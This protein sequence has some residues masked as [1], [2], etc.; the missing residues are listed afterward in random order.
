MTTTTRQVLVGVT[1]PGENTSALRWAA[2]E[3]AARHAGVTLAHVV[4]TLLPPPPPSVLITAP[5]PL[6]V[7]HDLMG[8]LVAEYEGLTGQKC[9]SV[10][11]Q[12]SPARVLTDLSET[13]ELVVVAHRHLP[14]VRRI[15]TF[16][17]TTSLGAHAHCP[18][19]AVPV[20][21]PAADQEPAWVTVGVPEGHVP[22][23]VLRAAF[24]AAMSRRLPLRVVHAWRAEPRYEHIM[25]PGPSTAEWD[26][27]HREQMAAAV[28][29]LA[30]KHPEVDVELLVPHQYPA[31]ALA[32]LAA[33]SSLLVV[34]RHAPFPPLPQ[35]IGSIART[36][37]RGTACPVMVVPVT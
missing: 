36:A 18:V 32:G 9:A 1:A 37:L 5:P 14:T 10:V 34:G 7:G 27:H 19:V 23:S 26:S 15:V 21:W 16:S 31:D 8:G 13:A 25:L 17:T 6:D 30:A 24:E 22:E 3:A 12:G 29:P 2:E 28:E 35:R 33:T 4:S 11:Q 20:D